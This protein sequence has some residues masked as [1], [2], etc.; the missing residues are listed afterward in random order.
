[1][2]CERAPHSR[3]Q[4][5]GRAI[6]QAGIT[7]LDLT[8]LIRL[9][10]IVIEDQR[11][12]RM[13]L[14]LEGGFVGEHERATGM[15]LPDHI[16]ASPQ[17][18][19]SLIHGLVAFDM[20]AGSE[21]DP[22]LAA[23]CLAFGFVYIHPFEDGNGRLH[24]YLI[25]YTLAHRKFHPPGVV[26]PVSSAILD[27]ID[28]YR[29]VLETYSTR[30]LPAIEWRATPNGNV[31]V[32]HETADFYRYFDATPHAEFLFAAIE[33]T[34]FED[35]PREARFLVRYDQFC[36]RL[37]SIVDMP[38]R[39]VDLLFRFLSQ[40]GGTL[41]KRARTQEFAALTEDEVHAIQQ[42]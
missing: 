16:D 15:P 3:I 8:E 40:Q 31:V 4:R 41:S 9:Q 12:T 37:Q 35:L 22:I 28:A 7:A 39:T 14:R 5:W 13:G 24:R 20:G 26:F 42:L 36:S 25:H 11:F 23:A 21:R 19:D 18:L 34:I 38:D 6:G 32:T 10:R 33:Q 2:N 17:D 1:M 30:L 27:R 29:T